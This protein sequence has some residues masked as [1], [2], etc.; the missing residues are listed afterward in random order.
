ML[1]SF[2]TPIFVAVEE[3]TV[4]GYGICMIKTYRQDP[5][6]SDHT[7]LYIDDLC[8]DTAHREQHIG[9]ALY[10]AICD[11]ARQ[12][13]CYSITLN[14]WTC[15]SDALKFYEAL[16]LQPQK[17]GMETILEDGSC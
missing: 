13:K 3:D 15:N 2:E 5:V 9:T 4:L 17:I 10:R 14:V 7:E 12:R 1:S 16:G 11:Y 6:I 8:V